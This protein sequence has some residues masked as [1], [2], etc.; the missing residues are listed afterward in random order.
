[1]IEELVD[2][3]IV[4]R[5]VVDLVQQGGTM[6]GIGLLGYTYIMERAGIRFRSMAGTSAG[7]INALLLSALPE[8]IYQARS[9]FEPSRKAVKSEMLAY[10]VANKDFSKF[11]DRKGTIG[12]L[13]T[14]LVS[15]VDSIRRYI[16]IYSLL[17]AGALIGIVYG[18]YHLVYALLFNSGSNLIEHRINNFSFI[19]GTLAII[20]FILLAVGWVLSLFKRNMG[21][22]PG[23]APYEWMKKILQTS[24]V[25]IMTT[26]SLMDKKKNEP[27]PKRD[28]ITDSQRSA[29]T[30]M[31]VPRLVFIAANL[32]HNRIVKFPENAIDYWDESFA[33]LV[34][35]AAYVRA[36][37]SIPFIFYAFIPADRYIDGYEDQSG[38]DKVKLL[39]RFVDGGML[40]NF[41]IREFH[42]P[43]PQEPAY[44]TF[45]VLL[46]KTAHEPGK[47]TA[48]I[49]KRFYSVSVFKYIV[50]FISTFRNFY[51]SEFLRN[52]KE[53][54]LLVKSVKT[55]RFNSFDFAMSFETKRK[56]FAAGART[57]IDQ[58]EHFN[59]PEYLAVRMGQNG[60]INLPHKLSV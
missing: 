51:D 11:L 47:K 46:G 5:P 27:Q 59:W 1:V 39:A 25:N 14:W 37:M 17:L 31:S 49:R 57:A 52:H 20:A 6:L 33:G 24:Y 4:H 9:L 55:G 16:W 34:H 3:E 44:P 18:I 43:S 30:P 35:P 53:I 26:K 13:Q 38:T 10:L 32:T 48:D 21:A 28:I 15:K 8:K 19:S 60:T 56:I 50:S 40:S 54:S 12:K 58:L 45:G 2:G 23:E 22:N 29:E 36:S 7:A 41:P 42:V